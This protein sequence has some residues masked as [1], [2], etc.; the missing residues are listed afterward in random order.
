MERS[1]WRQYA[2]NK[3]GFAGTRKQS[4][5]QQ[6]LLVTTLACAKNESTEILVKLPPP[7]ALIFSFS[8]AVRNLQDVTELDVLEA[9]HQR[10][11]SKGCG[12][13]HERRWKEEIWAGVRRSKRR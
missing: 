3:G 2:L 1:L 13:E 4:S 8:G 6:Q 10:R 9:K 7:E 12:T 11:H 5:T